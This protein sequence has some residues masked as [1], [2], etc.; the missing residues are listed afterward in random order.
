[1]GCLAMGCDGF[2]RFAGR[3][4][5]SI[6][7]IYPID[8]AVK[9]LRHQCDGSTTHLRGSETREALAEMEQARHQKK[10]KTASERLRHS[11][12]QRLSISQYMLVP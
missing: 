3:S 6:T 4:Y 10:G 7:M 8:I 9:D 12:R 2:G 1:M 5:C 11:V